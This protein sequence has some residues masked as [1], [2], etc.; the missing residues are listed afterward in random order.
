MFGPVVGAGKGD[1]NFLD[2]VEVEGRVVPIE[3]GRG[4]G[5]GYSEGAEIVQDPAYEEAVEHERFAF[6]SEDERL[7]GEASGFMA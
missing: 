1:G 3:H 4:G 5:E 7:V 6:P 2:E